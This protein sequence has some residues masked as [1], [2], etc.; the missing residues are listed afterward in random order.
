MGLLPIDMMIR[1]AEINGNDSD[2]GRFTELLYL[3]ELLLKMSAAAFVAGVEN[4]VEG[5][6]YRLHHELVRAD[7]IGEWSAKLDEVLS[8]VASQHLSSALH[9]DRRV[10]TERVSEGAWQYDAV[11][12]MHATLIGVHQNDAELPTKLSL[13]L[14]FSKFAE[15]RN[16]TRGHGATTPATCGRLL[17]FLDR[18][19]TLMAENNP[20][21]VRPWTYLHRNI[22]GKY[23]VIA[24][25]GD[26][27]VFA[28]LK[29]NLAA[30]KNFSN[31]IYIWAGKPCLVELV[32]T[33]VNVSDF[34]VA[35]G[36]FNGKSFEFISLISDSRSRID[37]TPYLAVAGE[38]PASETEGKDEFQDVGGVSSNLPAAPADYIK[39]PTLEAEVYRAITNDRHPVVTLV[40]RGGIGK[41]SL[42][43]TVLAQITNTK[44]F[45]TMVW[46]SARDVDLTIA[47]PKV[48]RPSFLTEKEIAEQYLGLVKIL[49]NDN[50]KIKSAVDFMAARLRDDLL[51]PTLF[52]FDNFET[53]RNPV[54]LFQWLDTHVRLPNKVV[55]TSRFR[56]FKADFPVEVQGMEREEV[57]ELIDRTSRRLKIETIMSHKDREQ[58]IEESGG[59]PYIVKIILGE[60]ASTGTFGKPSNMLA[61]KDDILDALF[62]RTYVNL[63]PLAVRAFLILSGWRSLVPQIALEAVLIRR[64]IEGADPEKAVD[65]LVRMSLVER[66]TA[67]DGNDFL[68][69]PLT[70]ALFGKKKFEVSSNRDVVEGDIKFLQDIG[71]T[72]KSGL[73]EGIRPR[74]ITLFKRAARAIDDGSSSWDSLRP[75]LEFVAGAYHPAW[76]FLAELE[77]EVF[78]K[79]GSEGAARHIRRFLE[80]QPPAEHA[81][82]AWDRL[83]SIYRDRDDARGGCNAFLRSAEIADPDLDQISAIANWLN[84]DRDVI[85]TTQVVD[86]EALFRPLAMLFERHIAAAS[87]TDI[88]RLAWLHLHAGNDARALELAEIGLSREIGN[89][90]C[91][92]LVERLTG[93]GMLSSG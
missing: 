56:E 23:R 42:A 36:N 91:Q 11:R 48:V 78:G 10:F 43:L 26:Q 31:G 17:P 24:L 87:A 85:N 47:G 83:I 65:E 12:S 21:F 54:D 3:G 86:R 32:R 81:R 63:S 35:N 53:A 84:N 39:R 59:H 2:V 76:L 50:Q 88:S 40:G 93:R 55:I 67:E 33:D 46:F 15:L 20:L 25:G 1:R 60:V 75:M 72:S 9:E 4:D 14:W 44:R 64:G 61:R 29:T 73:K 80:T 41:T 27:S 71:A 79:S 7:G 13:R 52:V 6:R 57:E 51:G 30:T 66:I 58:I 69:V 82:P 92:R 18:A 37:A 5:Y 28:D 49:Y 38:R 45:E 19:I 8:G 74:I 22:S 70:A 34:S 16:K 62:E 90:H 77:L 68:S 89:R